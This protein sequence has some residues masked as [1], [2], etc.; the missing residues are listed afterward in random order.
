MIKRMTFEY[1]LNNGFSKI[2][3]N[4]F[5]SIILKINNLNKNE[6]CL[7]KFISGKRKGENCE[8]NAIN[9]GYCG[10]HQSKAN[11]LL[12]NKDK[13]KEPK[14]MTKTQLQIIEWLNTAVPQT[15]TIL[16]K[17]SKGLL[18]EETEIIFNI[19]FTVIGKLNNGNII[20]ISETDVEMCEKNGWKYDLNAVESEDAS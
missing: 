1:S 2:Y 20:K 19:D 14:A 3:N 4:F 11:G 10:S 8:N 16:K 18:H 7:H 13:K 12:V 5:D 9:C 15:E 6:K 17:R